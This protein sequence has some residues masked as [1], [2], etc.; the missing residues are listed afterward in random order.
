MNLNRLKIKIDKKKIYEF[1]YVYKFMYENDSFIFDS[2]DKYLN[3]INYE[4][5]NI[6]G[7]KYFLKNGRKFKNGCNSCKNENRWSLNK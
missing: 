6:N 7:Y 4:P 3:Y 1:F 5:R 2:R